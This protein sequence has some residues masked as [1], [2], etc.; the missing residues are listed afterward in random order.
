MEFYCA[1]N[2]AHYERHS[3]VNCVIMF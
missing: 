2:N 3:S 1:E